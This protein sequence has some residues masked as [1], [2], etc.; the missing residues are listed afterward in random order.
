M[1]Y[2]YIAFH[3]PKKKQKKEL[4]FKFLLQIFIKILKCFIEIYIESFDE[5]NDLKISTI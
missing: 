5:L 1:Y 2:I 4:G 3:L